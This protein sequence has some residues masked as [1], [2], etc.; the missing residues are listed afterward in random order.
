[1]TTDNLIND[2]RCLRMHL[3]PILNEQ[4][5]NV[6][7]EAEKR[8]TREVSTSSVKPFKKMRTMAKPTRKELYDMFNSKGL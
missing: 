1:M 6:L 8:L 5:K 7:K 4:N 2:L 3:S